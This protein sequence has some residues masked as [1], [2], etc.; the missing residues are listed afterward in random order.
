[1]VVYPSPYFNCEARLRLL[2]DWGKLKLVLWFDVFGKPAGMTVT[3][4]ILLSFE[5][6][7]EPLQCIIEFLGNDATHAS[8]QEL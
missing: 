3:G 2:P 1:M 7:A 6:M 5:F 4:R 8:G